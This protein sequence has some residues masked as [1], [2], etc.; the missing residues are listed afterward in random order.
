MS[1]LNVLQIHS[2]GSRAKSVTRRLSGEFIGRLIA[3]G[4]RVATRDLADG[5]P[6]VD[7]DWIAANFTPA[8]QRTADQ[9]AALSF[10]DNLIAELKAAD[11]IVI[12]APVYN[13]GAPAVLKAWIDQ[14]M[15]ARVTFQYTDRGPVGLL[16]GKRAVI[17]MASGGTR[18][19]S[20]ADFAVTY[21]KFA[22]AFMGITDVSII[23]A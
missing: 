6:F 3:E 8:E 21:L 18:V 17:I 9:T 16:K 1:T 5:M 7:E 23:A 4:A 12:G 13:F 2:S 22:L 15:R 10:S 20:P 19:G 14:V 11:V